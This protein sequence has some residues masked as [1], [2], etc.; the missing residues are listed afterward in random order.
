VEE[1]AISAGLA[2][3]Q[4]DP[5]LERTREARSSSRN[6]G[7]DLQESFQV[8]MPISPRLV[9]STIPINML[10]PMVPPRLCFGQDLEVIGH[11]ADATEMPSLAAKRFP[12]RSRTALIQVHAA[13]S[14]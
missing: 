10:V 6:L 13:G 7:Q 3:L 14:G 12:T 5:R 4:V 1:D 11:S 2:T 9:S 8:L